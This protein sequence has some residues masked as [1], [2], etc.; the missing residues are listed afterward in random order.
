MKWRFAAAALL[1]T[2]GMAS[3]TDEKEGVQL[4]D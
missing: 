2:L 3:C 4:F 1:M